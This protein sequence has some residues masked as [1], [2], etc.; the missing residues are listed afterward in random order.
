LRIGKWLNWITVFAAIVGAGGLVVIWKTLEVT[1]TA[2]NLAKVQADAA[3]EQNRPWIKIMEIKLRGDKPPILALSFQRS[4]KP[5]EPFPKTGEIIQA[6]LQVEVSLK[7]V[8][9]S[10][11]QAVFVNSE[12][13]FSSWR[14]GWGDAVI[15]E[16][17]RF[18][19]EALNKEPSP[20]ASRSAVFPDDPVKWYL[21]AV[22]AVRPD[23]ITY[24]ADIPNTSYVVGVLITC[25][26]YQFS[27]AAPKIYQT[28]TMYELFRAE[29]RSRLFE[30][31][32]D[33]SAD[34]IL[35]IRDE[36]ADYAQ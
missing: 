2:V 32:A 25:V 29:N 4:P 20:F 22:S 8:G 18:C 21:G 12:L 34:E 23:N 24:V 30:V 33:L 35:T 15:Q 7:N 27:V 16:Q 13:F 28:R 26:N 17:K 19:D 11:A 31:G 36:H 3:E 5:D 6:T 9:H 10:V 14:N 1:Q